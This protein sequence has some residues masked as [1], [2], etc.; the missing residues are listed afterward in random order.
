MYPRVANAALLAARA[1]AIAPADAA[2]LIDPL[3]PPFLFWNLP[4]PPSG[5]DVFP[6][7]FFCF[8]LPL[9]GV[10]ERL[11]VTPSTLPMSTTRSPPF[12][13]TSELLAADM[14][15]A[16][17][18]L[19]MR[20]EGEVE[21]FGLFESGSLSRLLGRLFRFFPFDFFPCSCSC[22]F[23]ACLARTVCVHACVRVCVSELG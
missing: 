20:G 15:L 13:A 5:A 18:L 16:G 6:L 12:I 19:K 8:K 23:S 3:P 4:R 7:C 11:S 17:L 22:N 21:T 1:P 10:W 9:V 14:T 2:A